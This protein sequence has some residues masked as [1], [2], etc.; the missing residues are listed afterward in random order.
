MVVTWSPTLAATSVAL[1]FRK[2][3]ALEMLVTP[4]ATVCVR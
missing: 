1:V 4:A 3:N 2:P